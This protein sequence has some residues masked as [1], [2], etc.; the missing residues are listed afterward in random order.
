MEKSMFKKIIIVSLM[1]VLSFSLVIPTS[2]ASAKGYLFK[3]NGVTIGIDSAAKTF[4]KK[5]G[6]PVKTSVK[7]SCA[8]KGKDRAYKYKNFTLTTYSKSAKGAEYV[9][10]ITF[11][12]S[13]VSTKEGLKIG[14]K[15]SDIVKK[16]GKKYDAVEKAVN[17]KYVYKKA[18][19]TLQITVK[20]KKVT[21][22][23]YVQTNVK[24]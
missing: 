6:K 10:G 15:E 16:Y 7:K 1:F 21:K 23:S 22:I 24:K 18:N 13:K 9:N 20:K 2:A 3:Y 14:S 11:T 8:Y 17:N 5:A 12:T 4:I 19:C